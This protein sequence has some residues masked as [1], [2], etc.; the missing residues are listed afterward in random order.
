MTKTPTDLRMHKCFAFAAR[1]CPRVRIA[2]SSSEHVYSTN[3]CR[4]KSVYLLP[5]VVVRVDVK[6]DF[7]LGNAGATKCDVGAICL[8]GIG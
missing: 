2:T 3:T 1:P 4:E 8:L 7:T 5:S 6:T